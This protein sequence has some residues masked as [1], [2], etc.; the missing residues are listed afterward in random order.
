[1][2]CEVVIIPT[3][4]QERNPTSA[5]MA[6][7]RVVLVSCDS[8]GYVEVDD[9]RAKAQAHRETLAALMVT[10][11]STYGIFE[12]RIREICAIVHE[13]GGQVYLD[14]ANMNAQVGLTSPATIG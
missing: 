7:M 6:G 10:Y 4:G 2:N 13:H 3:S 9:L 1:M 5:T 11:P 12:E 8:H 14:G